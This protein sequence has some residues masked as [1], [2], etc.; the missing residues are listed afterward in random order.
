MR[1][2]RC[3]RIGHWAKDYPFAAQ[4]Q[5]RQP[6]TYNPLGLPSIAEVQPEK[7]HSMVRKKK[8]TRDDPTQFENLA[9]VLECDV[10]FEYE[11]SAAPQLCVKG[12]LRRT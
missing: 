12:N 8:E 6:Y 5:S 4:P 1:C 9:K 7:I 10:S 11:A 2:Y 3:D